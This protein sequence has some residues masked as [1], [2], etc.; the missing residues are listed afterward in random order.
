VLIDLRLRRRAAVVMLLSLPAAVAALLPLASVTPLAAEPTP[1]EFAQTLQRKYDTIRDFSAD[2][3]HTY[4]GGVL[5][6]EIVER[7]RVFIKKPGKMRWDYTAPE[8][9]RFVSDGV[10]MYSYIPEDKQV[11]ISS[12]PPDDQATTPTMFLAGKGNLARDFTSSFVD[13]PAGMPEGTRALKLVP[14]SSQKDYDWLILDVTPSTMALRGLVTADAQGGL[15]SFVFDNLKENTGLA[16][17]EF[18]FKIPRGADV[19]TDSLSR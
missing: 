19:V 17:K 1:S 6:K 13:L 14:K 2:F 16:D 15:S 8:E 7:G 9:K 11:V 10:K 12:I 3:V 18:A 5:R 4:R